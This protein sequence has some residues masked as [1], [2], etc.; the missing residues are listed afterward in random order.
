MGFRKVAL[1]TEIFALTA[2]SSVGF[3]SWLAIQTTPVSNEI[4]VNVENIVNT[5]KYV[6]IDNMR[7]SELS[8]S[9]FVDDNIING[10]AS[11]IASLDFDI[12]FDLNTYRTIDKNT[13]NNDTIGFDIELSSSFTDIDIINLVKTDTSKAQYAFTKTGVLSLTGEYDELASIE[14]ITKEIIDDTFF[15][16]YDLNSTALKARYGLKMS[17]HYEFD[18]SSLIGTDES[19][20]DK[21]YNVLTSSG[22]PKD[23]P[24]NIVVALNA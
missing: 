7:F 3:S 15:F 10:T 16:K 9:G 19:F 24:F 11:T 1:L 8:T 13:I 23:I 14:N 20:K 18:F 5:D 22:V 21:V 4:N 17:Y 6:T 2:M 12:T